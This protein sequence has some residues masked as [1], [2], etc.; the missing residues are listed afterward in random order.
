MANTIE[1]YGYTRFDLDDCFR[2]NATDFIKELVQI[3]AQEAKNLCRKL[4]IE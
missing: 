4:K 1:Q 3:N 2:L